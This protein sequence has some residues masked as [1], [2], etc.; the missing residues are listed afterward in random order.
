[1]DTISTQNYRL[2]CPSR[3]EQSYIVQMA[4]TILYDANRRRNK[5]Y[6]V[7][8]Y[9][10]YCR[11]DVQLEWIELKVI[12]LNKMSQLSVISTIYWLN[13]NWSFPLYTITSI[14]FYNEYFKWSFV[15]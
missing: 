6:C 14:Y 5:L 3:T 12:L 2:R 7:K 13:S 4:K 11:K 9:C 1:M 10:S 8:T 15:F